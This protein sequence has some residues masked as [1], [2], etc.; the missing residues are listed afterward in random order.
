[1]GYMVEGGSCKDGMPKMQNWL[2]KYPNE[3]RELLDKLAEC[4]VQYL[5]MQ[6]RAGA[7]LLQVFESSAEH[8]TVDEFLTWSLP[9]LKYIREEVKLRSE[10]EKLPIVPMI[11]FAKGAGHSLH[12]QSQI[13]YEVLSIDWKMDPV[14]ARKAVGENVTLQG[15]LNPEDMLK[16][17]NELKA[18]IEDM[19]TKF[20][21]KRYIANLGHG[22]TPKTPI[23]SMQILTE[24]VHKFSTK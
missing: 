14:E 5:L 2:L 24:T 1:M 8:M 21:S 13:G 4:C 11:L 3:T 10:K 18:L 7:Q 22:I 6:V 9:H 23:E 15:N 16:S 19:L 17:P 20:G 12:K